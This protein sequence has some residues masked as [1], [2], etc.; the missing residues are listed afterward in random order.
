MEYVRSIKDCVRS[1]SNCGSFQK[2]GLNN[3]LSQGLKQSCDTRWNSVYLMLQS[4]FKNYD[5]IRTIFQRKDQEAR[6]EGI[7][8]TTVNV[9]VRFLLPFFEGTKALEGDLTPTI[10]HVY[11]WYVKL[12]RCMTFQTSDCP[13]LK[14]LKHRGFQAIDNKFEITPLHKLALFSNPKLKS[15]NAFTEDEKITI[16]TLLLTT[17]HP[18][19]LLSMSVQTA[20]VRMI[21][22]MLPQVKFALSAI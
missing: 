10:H 15:L 17:Y 14:F 9:L 8:I 18:L 4:F 20:L 3:S 22:P 19:F 11:Q 12:K 2:T 21:V 5:E 13:L 7:V 6:L 16:K 1:K